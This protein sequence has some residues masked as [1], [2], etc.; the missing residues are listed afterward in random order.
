MNREGESNIASKQASKQN[1]I[2]H[3]AVPRRTTCGLSC[4]KEANLP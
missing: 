3:V 1:A 4:C 2:E